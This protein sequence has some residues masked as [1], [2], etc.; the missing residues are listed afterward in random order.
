MRNLVLIILFI[1]VVIFLTNNTYEYY[2][3]PD[4]SSSSEVGAGASAF[5]NWG[6]PDIID[7]HKDKPKQPKQKKCPKCDHVYIDNEVCNIVIDDRHQCRNCDITKNKDIDKYVLK[8]SVPPCPDLSN[9]ATKSMLQPDVNLDNYILKSKL[10]EYCSSYYPDKNKYML[11]TQCP[12]N[13]EDYNKY[14]TV[15]KDITKHPDYNKYV[16]KEHCKKYKKSWIQDFD[17][18]WEGL[19]SKKTNTNG[20]NNKNHNLG[21]FPQGYSYSPYAGYGL[22][23][24]GYALDGGYVKERHF[25]TPEGNQ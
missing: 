9:Y 17:E 1:I 10:P 18:W 2:E 11:K 3:N 23:N 5:F 14:Q 16:S 8:S 7:T 22:D 15:Y 13:N 6:G 24:P 20:N 19:F 4:V 12:A 25:A 21:K